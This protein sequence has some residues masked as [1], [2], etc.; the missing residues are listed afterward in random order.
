MIT[1]LVCYDIGNDKCRNKVSKKLESW[2]CIRIQY[3]VFCGKHKQLLWQRFYNELQNVIKRYGDEQ[4]SIYM[5]SI[6]AQALKEMLH[7]GNKP[8]VDA[9]LAEPIYVFF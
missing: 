5:M 7:I 4:D 1:K 8:N 6:S 3:S 9:I 2:G